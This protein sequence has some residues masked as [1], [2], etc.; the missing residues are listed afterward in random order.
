MASIRQ[1][2][3]TLHIETTGYQAAVATE[4]YVSGVMPGSFVDK[5]TGARDPGY[6]LAIVDFLL[7][8]GA[9]DAA[10]PADLRY[11]WG[12]ALLL[13]GNIPKR[14]VE[15]PQICTQ[16]GKLPFEIVEGR[17]FV[18]VRQWFRWTIARPPYQPGSLWEQWLVFPDGVRWFLA[19]DQVTSA[20]DVDCLLLRMDMPGHIKHQR[21]DTFQQIYLSYRGCLPAEVFAE[22][23][24]PDA[25]YFYRREEGSPPQRFIRACQL[26][27]DAWLAGMALEPSAVY[28]AWC[29]Q[30]GYV[31]L[32]Q[33]IGGRAVR[34]GETFGAVH[35]IGYF[36]D[37]A[38]I[39]QTFDAHKGATAL[40]VHSSG[41][42]LH[43]HTE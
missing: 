2:G 15:L 34:A 1:E 9:D 41:W 8:P 36:E 39:E 42:E 5:R 32:I 18:A 17:N 16:A 25:R 40:R 31:C 26:S 12:E 13:H 43:T 10:T 27:N 23:F 14:F 7:E 28:E 19:W 30:R 38:D 24:P 22:D 11:A 20:N 35:L 33:E 29:H 6:G 3:T 4:G 37:M 21:G